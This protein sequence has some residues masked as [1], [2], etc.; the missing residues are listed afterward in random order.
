M[1]RVADG[2]H[3]PARSDERGRVEPAAQRLLGGP[4]VVAREAQPGVEDDDRGVAL[5]GHRLGAHGGDHDRRRWAPTRSTT[6]SP[7]ELRTVV[8]VN[9]RPSSSAV[10]ASP[11]TGARSPR[12]PQVPHAQVASTWPHQR[13]CGGTVGPDTTSGPVQ[14]VQ[15][16]GARQVSQA[17]EAA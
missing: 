4:H 2:H 9:I 6:R 12:P 3:V 14:T 13:H 16:A 11:R 17:S 15:R 1:G 10:R 7:L 8:P 5:V